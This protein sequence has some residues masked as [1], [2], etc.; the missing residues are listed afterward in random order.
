[1]RPELFSYAI[2]SVLI[3][4][5]MRGIRFP[6]DVVLAGVLQLAWVNLHSYFLV[7][8]LVT[9]AWGPCS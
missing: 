5:L 2:L 4:L 6:R 1:M 8:I 9:A 3:A 7:G